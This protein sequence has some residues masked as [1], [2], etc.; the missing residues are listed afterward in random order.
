ML[1]FVTIEAA[2]YWGAGGQDNGGALFRPIRF[3]NKRS[4]TCFTKRCALAYI[5]IDCV[6]QRSAARYVLRPTR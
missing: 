5:N 4:P 3:R 2:G 6:H 1:V